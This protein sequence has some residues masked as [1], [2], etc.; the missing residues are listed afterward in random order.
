MDNSLAVLHVIWS[1]RA[2]LFV[3]L[4]HPLT[5]LCRQVPIVSEDAMSPVLARRT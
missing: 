1:V 3:Y 2:F 5:A 4:F